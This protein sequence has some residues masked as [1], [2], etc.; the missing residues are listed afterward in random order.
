[1]SD[2]S[3]QEQT[4]PITFSGFACIIGFILSS[5]CAVFMMLFA[6]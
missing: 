4:L 2:G 5:L 3:P 1:M 6:L